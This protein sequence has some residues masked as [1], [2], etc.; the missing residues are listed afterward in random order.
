[1]NAAETTPNPPAI[2]KSIPGFTQ[3]IKLCGLFVILSFALSA[4]LDFLKQNT[5]LSLD[6]FQSLL[7]TQ[8]IAWPLT[9]GAG[10]RWSK[11]PFGI[12]FPLKRLPVQTVP[13]L[14]ITS[15]GATILL[16][17]LAGLIPAPEAYTKSMTELVVGSSRPALFFAAVVAAPLGEEFFF[18]G[19]VLN[20]YL[21]RYSV[22]K[23]VWVS[24]ALF[25][26]FHLN[27]WQAVVALPLGLGF[28]GLR[29]RTGSLI[30]CIL[31]HAAVNFS[32]NFL[33]SPLEL[34]LG[35]D[36]QAMKTLHHFPPSL[37]VIG[38]AMTGV[39]GFIVW[40]QLAK[41]TNGQTG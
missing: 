38:I 14:L 40:Q 24:A 13:A 22:T 7:I 34:A 41:L 35:Y 16:L 28:A 20:G 2:P 21:G 32:T 36:A 15:F 12:A 19:W 23:A 33:L 1:M 6:G 39:G 26:A 29:Q 17:E 30:P 27:P 9:L 31:C 10:L 25:A 3:S 4:G 8:V 11:I 5:G 18:R 37:L